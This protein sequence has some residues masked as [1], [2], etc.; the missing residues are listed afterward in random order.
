[1]RKPEVRD[2]MVGHLEPGEHVLW[3]GYPDP[4]VVFVRQDAYLIPFS[5]LWAGFS[6]F[7]EGSAAAA[8][9]GFVFLVFG[10]AFALVGLYILF[11]RFVYKRIDRRHTRYFVTNHR[12]IVLRHM[13]RDLLS[14]PLGPPA[15]VQRRRDGKHATV[16]WLT[17]AASTATRWGFPSRT[18][19]AAW[20]RGTGWPAF[21]STVA[22]EVAFV[23]VSNF[24]GLLKSVSRAMGEQPSSPPIDQSRTMTPLMAAPPGWYPDPAGSGGNLWWDGSQWWP[25]SQRLPQ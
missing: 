6:F 21:G 24:D 12:I 14:V 10:G 1:M 7:W 11:G 13:G 25:P 15:I 4:N 8:H 3:Q 17:G 9:A 2:W 5:L 23:D 19:S 20:A 22:G 16:V 18:G